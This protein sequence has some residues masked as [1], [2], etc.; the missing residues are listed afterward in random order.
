MRVLVVDPGLRHVEKERDP[1]GPLSF[2][3]SREPSGAGD[4]DL[5]VLPVGMVLEGADGPD[6]GTP[7]VAYGPA[8]LAADAFAEGCL[9]YLREPWGLEELEA[10]ALRFRVRK[11]RLGDREYSYS[12]G[13]LDG[14][15][16]SLLLPEVERGI[17]EL[18]LSR[19]GRAVP[20]AAFRLALGTE[21]PRK[22]RRL[23]MAVSRLRSRLIRASGDSRAGSFL[24][25]VRNRGYRLSGTP[26]G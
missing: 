15:A 7:R 26:C 6:A 12:S 1:G 21:D 22:S 16:L 18:L 5:V 20:R 14:A 3:F 13:R 11:F 23:D 8:S 25:A 17:L 2:F 10:R 24:Q 19:L 9:D 4:F